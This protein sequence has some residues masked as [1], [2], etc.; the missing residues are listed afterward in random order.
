MNEAEVFSDFVEEGETVL[1]IGKPAASLALSPS[2]RAYLLTMIFMLALLG[3]LARRA[4]DGASDLSGGLVLSL[5]LLAAIGLAV[6]W[7]SGR[8]LARSLSR[9]R[10]MVYCLTDRRALIVEET[11]RKAW[12][13]LRIDYDTPVAYT[14]ARGRRGHIS[15]GRRYDFDTEEWPLFRGFTFY[16]IKDPA[17]VVRL[18]EDLQKSLAPPGAATGRAKALLAPAAMGEAAVS[19]E[20][21]ADERG[22]SIFYNL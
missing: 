17:N 22:G 14:Q 13:W 5:A 16:N 1:W 8:P 21:A 9:R 20:R 15:F 18:V 6:V 10:R 11:K 19:P 7:L 4:L 3:L 12:A 2:E